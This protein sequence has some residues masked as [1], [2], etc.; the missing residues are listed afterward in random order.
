[1]TTTISDLG[2]KHFAFKNSFR[3]LS[4]PLCVFTDVVGM[5]HSSSISIDQ[6]S[7]YLKYTYDVYFDTRYTSFLRTDSAYYITADKKITVVMPLNMI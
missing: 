2:G 6:G 7:E 4:L 3:W 5:T 1:M